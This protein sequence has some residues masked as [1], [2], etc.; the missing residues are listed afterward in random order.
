ML[1][2]R[3]RRSATR[4]PWRAGR[5]T[6]RRRRPTARTR[7]GPPQRG[8]GPVARLRST[9]PASR[10]GPATTATSVPAVNATCRPTT[11]RRQARRRGQRAARCRPVRRTWMA[12]AE[13]DG[14]EEP[15]GGQD[16][17]AEVG[18]RATVSN[19]SCSCATRFSPMP[20]HM[21]ALPP[22]PQEDAR[23][24]PGGRDP[25]PHPRRRG[26]CL[27]PARVRGRH[28]QPHR[29]RGGAVDRLALPVLPQQ[30]RHPRGPRA[31]PRGRGRRGRPGA[32]SSRRR[33]PAG[34]RP[35][36]PGSGSIVDA[37]VGVHAGDPALHQVLFEQA[38]R[39]P[40][41]LAELRALEDARG[42]R[43]PPSCSPAGRRRTARPDHEMAARLV[44]TTIES[45]VHRLVATRR[46]AAMPVDDVRRE[47]TA[48]V[49]RYLAGGDRPDAWSAPPRRSSNRSVEK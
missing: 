44:V 9:P 13:D 29:R 23:P 46:A 1:T 48:V 30:G 31:R 38:P 19:C 37:V 41:L 22:P 5:R 16:D 11:R 42:A 35:R 34:R 20:T 4:R 15:D 40:E 18:M 12:D 28:D 2:G 25:Q 8:I 43:R 17:S 10:T 45:L 27:L 32:R 49:V 47:V 6:C 39:P 7:P 24:G 3:R 21:S 26:S 33:P 36:R 14:G